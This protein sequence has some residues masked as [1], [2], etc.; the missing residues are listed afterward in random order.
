MLRKVN[1]LLKTT[2][3]KG[4]VR[5]LTVEGVARPQNKVSPKDLGVSTNSH[6]AG[7]SE[8][9]LPFI[10]RPC[11]YGLSDVV[12]WKEGRTSQVL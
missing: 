5:D 6:L 3:Q 11:R 10:G 4:T 8:S 9:I 1:T 12:T 7:P 2:D